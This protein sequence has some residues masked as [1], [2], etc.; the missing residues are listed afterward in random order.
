MD[1]ENTPKTVIAEDTEITGSVKSTGTIQVD[2]KLNGDLACNNNA[3]I[4][5]STIKFF[6]V[7]TPYS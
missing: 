3:I 6:M 1:G 2:G 4:T 5:T 7:L